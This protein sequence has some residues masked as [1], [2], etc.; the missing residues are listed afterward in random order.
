MQSLSMKYVVSLG[1]F[2]NVLYQVNEV[3]SIPSY[4]GFAF[5]FF[6]MSTFFCINYYGSVM[7]SCQ[8]LLS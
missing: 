4:L 2:V 3:P 6:I 8:L 7:F 1:F 5:F